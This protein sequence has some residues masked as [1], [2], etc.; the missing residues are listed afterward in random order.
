MRVSAA[1]GL[2]IEH[3]D[4]LSRALPAATKGDVTS[5]HKARVV[6]RRLRVALPIVANG[7]KAA[8]VARLVRRITQVLGPARDLDV[9]VEMLRDLEDEGKVSHAAASALRSAIEG[10]RARLRSELEHELEGVD[11]D[12]LRKRAAAAT[13]T[14]EAAAFGL[15]DARRAAEAR[16]EAGRRA[17]R[18]MRALEGA[19]A[20]YLPDRLHDV[21]IA[22]KKLRYTLEVEQRFS[23]S[24]ARARVRTLQAAQALLGRIHDLEVLIARTRATQASPGASSLKISADLDQLVRHLES[25]C[26]RLHGGYMLLRK[27]LLSLCRRLI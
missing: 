26:R 3:V 13:H 15:R 27:G 2:M 18:L 20:L 4:T 10:E 22:V 25:E 14:D 16:A 8:R 24:R 19:A 1:E 23:G 6:S 5:L 21:R 17:N 12:K 11:F 7:R 9:A